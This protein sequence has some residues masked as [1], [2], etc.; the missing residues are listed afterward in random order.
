MRC[1]PPCAQDFTQRSIIDG[2]YRFGRL[3]KGSDA[4]QPL[5]TVEYGRTADE[6]DQ[7]VEMDAYQT[8]DTACGASFVAGTGRGVAAHRAAQPGVLVEMCDHGIVNSWVQIPPGCG[9]KCVTAPAVQKRK[10]AFCL[11]LASVFCSKGC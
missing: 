4:Q 1:D 2:C 8:G 10:S 3:N 6:L 7:F 5:Y 9:E 11:S